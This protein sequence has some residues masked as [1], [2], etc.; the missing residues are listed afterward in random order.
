ML[1]SNTRNLNRDWRDE[2]RSQMRRLGTISTPPS[3]WLMPADSILDQAVVKIHGFD[4]SLIL[5]CDSIKMNGNLLDDVNLKSAIDF[6][7]QDLAVADIVI[8]SHS[9]LHKIHESPRCQHRMRFQHLM[10]RVQQ[11]LNRLHDHRQFLIDNVERLCDCPP[12]ANAIQDGCLSVHGLFYLADSGMFSLY[13]HETGQ[14]RPLDDNWSEL[15]IGT[16][17]LRPVSNS[18]L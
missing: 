13:H 11:H 15:N 7:I 2:L 6:A 8:C 12:V 14:F 4:S 10:H 18:H 3:L 16:K 1:I 9:E 5:R 17:A